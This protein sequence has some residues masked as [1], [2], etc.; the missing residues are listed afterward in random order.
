MPQRRITC[1]SFVPVEISVTALRPAATSQYS[2]PFPTPAP[3]SYPTEAPCTSRAHRRSKVHPR[4]R[5]NNPPQPETNTPAAH[6]IISLGSAAKSKSL[7]R[8]PIGRAHKNRPRPVSTKPDYNETNCPGKRFARRCPT[9]LPKGP[10]PSQ[11]V[12]RAQ[13]WPDAALR[14]FRSSPLL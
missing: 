10:L 6:L 2:T 3:A 7:P 4:R 11:S 12:L 5:T 14:S 8:G 13:P 1:S 9:L